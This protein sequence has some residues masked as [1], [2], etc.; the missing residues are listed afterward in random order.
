MPDRP[1][2]IRSRLIKYGN[3]RLDA[4]LMKNGLVDEFHILLMPVAVSSGQHMF[5]SIT[6][7]PA[8][9][10]ADHTAFEN[11]VVLLVYK[12]STPN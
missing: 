6:D 5:E 8:L 1:T 12:P 9:R 7:S 10:L 4:V 3:G 2:R 11:G